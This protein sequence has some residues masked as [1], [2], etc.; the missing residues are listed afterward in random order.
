[1]TAVPGL[2]PAAEAPSID[3]RLETVNPSAAVAPVI[4]PEGTAPGAVDVPLIDLDG[5]GI[6]GD[7]VDWPITAALALTS[8]EAV[9]GSM[10]FYPSDL[11]AAAD[12]K[13]KIFLS[14]PL[15]NGRRHIKL[16]A[17]LSG[18]LSTP[19]AEPQWS[20]LGRDTL[21]NGLLLYVNS[22]HRD[23]LNS[24]INQALK[25]KPETLYRELKSLYSGLTLKPKDHYILRQLAYT[26]ALRASKEQL[27]TPTRRNGYLAAAFINLGR[28]RTR[29]LTIERRM[30]IQTAAA[31]LIRRESPDAFKL[32]TMIFQEG[33]F[34]KAQSQLHFDDSRYRHVNS[35]IF[36]SI[37]V[38]L[39]AVMGHFEVQAFYSL[40]EVPEILRP[41]YLGGSFAESVSALF[42]VTML[43]A[44]QAL[45][46]YS[47][48]EELQKFYGLS[49]RLSRDQVIFVKEACLK[50]LSETG[51]NLN[52]YGAK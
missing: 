28:I 21:F 48:F 1:M 38:A 29:G 37:G 3:M 47:T 27:G 11:R 40:L 15:G 25:G 20:S 17:A 6:S 45:S 30:E 46:I 4:D 8:A 35:L 39:G 42:P 7:E 16:S 22:G 14:T 19:E 23:L 9:Q 26:V 13:T 36:L 44:I 43:S 2:A 50:A 52:G 33:G 12:T 5:N 34:R 41:R 31:S 32:L 49:P 24:G 18:A 51:A 10:D